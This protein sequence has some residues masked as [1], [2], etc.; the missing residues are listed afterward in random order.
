M[1]LINI[2]NRL[3]SSLFNSENS[4]SINNVKIRNINSN[5]NALLHFLYK[6]FSI[7]DL[8]I[9]DIKCTG[10]SGESSL[11][12]FNSGEASHK[13]D[14]SN[15]SVKKCSTNG[16]LISITGDSNEVFVK[17]SVIEDNISFG[18][19]IKNDSTKVK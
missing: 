10:D 13:L 19:G 11:I 9:S 1:H 5:S 8:S 7:K 3:T 18:T 16:P 12:L 17:D 15:L 14:I 6:N 4:I 2:T